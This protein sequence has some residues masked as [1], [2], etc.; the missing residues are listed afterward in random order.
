MI[1]KNLTSVTIGNSVTSIGWEAFNGC[2]SLTSIS[3]PDS[4]SINRGAFHYCTGFTSITIPDSV[5]RIGHGAFYG[6][7]N[8]TS[9]TV[10]F[11][12][13]SVDND[14]YFGY[15]FF[16]TRANFSQ[17]TNKLEKCNYHR[18]HKY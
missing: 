3:I 7:D 8:L 5:N 15:I 6:C 1:A 9:I 2:A 11:V 12:G 18:K 13:G 4:T 14:S 17:N 10:P 16:E